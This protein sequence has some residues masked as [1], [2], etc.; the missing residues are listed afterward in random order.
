ML[1]LFKYGVWAEDNNGCG[2]QQYW[3]VI[4]LAI[5]ADASKETAS[6]IST[7]LYPEDAVT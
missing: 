3:S 2:S 7:W 1:L 5:K 4:F 6:F